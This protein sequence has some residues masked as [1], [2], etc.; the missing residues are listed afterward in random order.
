[1]DIF[2]ISIKKKSDKMK[3][4]DSFIPPSNDDGSIVS[5]SSFYGLS[6]DLDGAVKDENEL[7]RRYRQA[8]EYPDCS[9]AVEEIVNEAIS[10]SSDDAPVTLN[11]NHIESLSENVKKA[12]AKE[13]SI[14]L[15]LFDFQDKGYDTFRQWYI[16]GK[17]YFHAVVD[18]ESPKKGIQDLR[19]VDP[20]K[21]RKIKEMVVEKDSHGNDIKKSGETY[22]LFNDSGINAA[23][24]SGVKL[25]LES[26]FCATSGI[27]DYNTGMIRS[28]LHNSIKI[29]NSLKYTEESL[30][31]Y[32]VSRAPERRVFYIDVGNLNKAKADQYIQDTMA[33]FR[34]KLVFNSTTGEINDN[35]QNQSMMEDYWLPR[36]DNSKTTEIT[37][38][39]GGCLSMDTKVSLLDGR[40]I[41]ISE[42]EQEMKTGKELWVYSC[43]EFTGQIKPGLI[44]WAGTTQKSAKVMKITLDNGESLICTPDHKFPIYGKGF[45]EAKDLMIDESMIPLYRKHEQISKAKKRGYEQFFDNHKKE[46]VFTHRMVCDELKDK[47]IFDYVYDEEYKDRTK[48]VRHHIDCNRFNNNPN[49]LCFMSWDDHAKLHSDLSFSEEA[50]MLGT[51]A[52]AEKLRIMKIEDP[53]A[54]KKRSDEIG[55]RTMEWHASLNETEKQEFIESLKK[56]NTEYWENI[57]EDLREHRANVSRTN[58][59]L[60]M[61]STQHKLQTDPIFYEF[62]C[63]Q[64]RKSWDDERRLKSANITKIISTERWLLRGDELRKKHKENQKLEIDNFIFKKIVDLIANK[65]TYKI[66]LEDVVNSLN[67]NEECVSRLIE[68]NQHKHIPNYDV[69]EGFTNNN[70]SRC[71]KDYGYKHWMDFRQ[72]FK[73]H[74]HRI[75]DIEYLDEEIEVGT[76]TIDGD[77]LYHNHHTFALTCGIFTKN[78]NLSDISDVTYFQN[79]L[80][81]SLHVPITRLIPE[82]SFSIGRAGEITRD[83]IKFSKFIT[84]LRSKFSKI[85]M[86]ALRLQC[87]LKGIISYEDF[88]TIEKQIRFNFHDDNHFAELSESEVLQNRLATLQ[89][90]DTYVGKYFDTNWV[91]KNI[92]KQS[93]EEIQEI[94]ERMDEEKP[95][96]EPTEEE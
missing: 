8:A 80:F 20:R 10:V 25:S 31:I 42:I 9:N 59:Y 4:V 29:I 2:G 3:R 56:G 84:R 65:S 43:D 50:Y 68:L 33:R 53:D 7:I 54:Y 72:K 87:V 95:L 38:L 28:H 89:L 81:R 62:F 83:E 27:V 51:R 13:F 79:K 64:N 82:Q 44:T 18:T 46:W 36:R 61:L 70:V 76:L 57:S 32:R 24:K 77:E 16:D 49:N 91:K 88:S 66:T 60:G 67:N 22:Y 21:I 94:Q 86:E 48:N 90:V 23:A 92:L 74:N 37:T 93:D 35:K 39:P 69:L 73:Y 11:L 19:Y 78:S 52:A 14:I 96:M 17:V 30:V 71:V 26:V 75:I 15:D 47:K 85:F 55:L 12:M 1:M 41:T 5:T 45:V 40:E 58:A 34:N 63:E 6:L